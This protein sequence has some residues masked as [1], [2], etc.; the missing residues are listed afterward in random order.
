MTVDADQI[1][2]NDVAI[3]QRTLLFSV[4]ESTELAA[5]LA[6]SRA[7]TAAA[8]TMLF[9]EHISATALYIVL[10]GAVGLLAP[11]GQGN[12]SL[13]EIVTAGQVIGEAGLFDTGH[14]PL[15]ARALTDAKLLEIP[16]AP[17]LSLI[18]VSAAFR[19]RLLSHSSMRLRTLVRQLTELKLMAVPQRLGAFLLGLT[20][21]HFGTAT[22]RLACERQVVAGMLGMTPES[23][24]RAFHTL[25]KL[26]VESLGRRSVRLNDITGLRSFVLTG[27]TDASRD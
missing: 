22:I 1:G 16:A 21:R 7:V 26:G 24:S 11:A 4:L 17:F 18:E 27:M 19:R 20:E 5:L 23:L 15:A 2:P 10:K 25:K 13:I 9:N 14:Y 8:G 3:V 12:Y 6:E